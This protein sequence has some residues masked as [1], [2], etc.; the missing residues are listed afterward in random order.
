MSAAFSF[1]SV[2]G[3]EMQDVNNRGEVGRGFPSALV[4]L[5]SALCWESC[6]KTQTQS[7]F[8]VST[9]SVMSI[10]FGWFSLSYVYTHCAF[11]DIRIPLTYLLNYCVSS[12][13]SIQCLWEKH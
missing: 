4:L 12:R 11:T 3:M 8:P 1:T 10:M 9:C 7:G 2:E 13:G 5:L 6:T